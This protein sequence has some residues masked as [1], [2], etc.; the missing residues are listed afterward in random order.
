MIQYVAMRDKTWAVEVAGMMRA[1]YATHPAS[2]PVAESHFQRTI[3]R[4]LARPEA[5]TIVLFIEESA[6]M[7]YAILIPYWSNEFGGVL[8]FIDELFVRAQSRGKGIAKG[9]LAQAESKSGADAVALAL[10]VDPQNTEAR[11]LYEALGFEK[12]KD[13]M[14]V[15]RLKQSTGNQTPA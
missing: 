14:L 4:L 1:L 6:L 5:G 2:H 15:K 10:E 3:D 9:F 13:E 12:R 11:R 7:G 8:L